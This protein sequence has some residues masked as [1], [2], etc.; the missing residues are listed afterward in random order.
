MKE[1]GHEF[2]A[3]VPAGSKCLGFPVLLVLEAKRRG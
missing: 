1:S 3:A 2:V